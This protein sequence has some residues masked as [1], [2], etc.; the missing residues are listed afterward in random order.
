MKPSSPSLFR[1]CHQW[2]WESSK[3]SYS[4]P[5]VNVKSPKT[6][7]F[8]RSG[9]NTQLQ[10]KP[11]KQNHLIAFI[12]TILRPRGKKSSKKNVISKFAQHIS[13]HSLVNL[14]KKRYCYN[15][16]QCPRREPALS[17]HI[18]NFPSKR[19]PFLCKRTCT[20]LLISTHF[21]ILTTNLHWEFIA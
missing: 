19:A 8:F 10:F 9:Q 5:L 1:T 18:V 21:F 13:Q 12:R 15:A 6:K 2:S 3:T 11:L 16:M 7:D 20:H 4:S 14:Q 17:M